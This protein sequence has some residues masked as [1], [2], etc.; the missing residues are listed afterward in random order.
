MSSQPW[1]SVI[2]RETI[3]CPASV[4]VWY[5]SAVILVFEPSNF[6]WLLR[7]FSVVLTKW[8]TLFTQIFSEGGVKEALGLAKVKI[9]NPDYELIPGSLLEITINF[10]TRTSLRVPDT[11]VM[12]E[13]EKVFVYTVSEDNIVNK[14]EIEIG[15][16]DQGNVEILSGLNL[17]DTIVAE[18]LKKVFPRGKIKPIKN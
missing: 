15:L 9:D 3:C 1:E 14:K 6:H 18:G 8:A 2:L 16:R 7:G 11:S 5:K 10:N 4:K 13:G 17:G 12:M